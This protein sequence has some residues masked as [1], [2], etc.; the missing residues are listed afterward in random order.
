MKVIGGEG[1]RKVTSVASGASDWPK[2]DRSLF[3]SDVQ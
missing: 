1:R 2:F 3:H